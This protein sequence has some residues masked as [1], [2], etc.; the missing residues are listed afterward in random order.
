M[1]KIAVLSDTHDQVA[2]LQTAI[3]YCNENNI[4]TLIHC[5]D[6]ISPFML[7]RLTKLN[8]EIHLIFGNN[9]GDRRLLDLCDSQF[10][11]IT[12][13]GT[14]ADM[15]LYGK[16][17]GVVHYPL[18]AKELALEGGFDIICYGHNHTHHVEHIG[19]T[20]LLNPGQMLGEKP[21]TGFVILDCKSMS[22]QRI[23]L[24]S[25]MFREQ[26]PVNSGAET[27]LDSFL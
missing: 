3:D 8:G 12:H 11:N 4:R 7:K 24:D 5:G 14:F 1:T 13:H 2:H 10:D 6:L 9:M 27:P 23:V 26:I 16:K 19:T 22:I 21:D 18:R 17:I 25:Y 15:E 20:I